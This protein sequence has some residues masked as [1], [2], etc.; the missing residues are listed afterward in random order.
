M[1]MKDFLLKKSPKLIASLLFYV[2]LSI[3]DCTRVTINTESAKGRK[4]RS[5]VISTLSQGQGIIPFSGAESPRT[6]P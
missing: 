1:M 3:S 4:G 2:N 6:V 5:R